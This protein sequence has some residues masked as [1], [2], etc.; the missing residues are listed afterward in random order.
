MNKII[1]MKRNYRHPDASKFVDKILVKEFIKEE[2]SKE[3]RNGYQMSKMQSKRC[4]E[5]CCR[6]W[7]G[8][9]Q[10]RKRKVIP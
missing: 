3:T 10:E 8:Q 9:R 6:Q 7:K 2:I 4:V 1:F 5:R